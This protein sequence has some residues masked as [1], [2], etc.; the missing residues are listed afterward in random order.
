MILVDSSIWVDYFR[1]SDRPAAKALQQAMLANEDI[2]IVPVI[3]TEVLMG[4][5][6]DRSFRSAR[7]VLSK[8]PQLPV[9]NDTYIRA[10]T[11]FRNLQK[12]GVTVRG[13]VDCI[14]AQTCLETSAELMTLDNDFREMARFTSLKVT[15]PS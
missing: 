12:K 15:L 6:D 5:R 9:T 11:L 1:D 2:A 7:T 10:A 13:A 3:L 14:I 8:V 4:F